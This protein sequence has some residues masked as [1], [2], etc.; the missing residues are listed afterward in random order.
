MLKAV[1]SLVPE[2]CLL[3][4]VLTSPYPKVPLSTR[5][6]SQMAGVLK[7]SFLLRKF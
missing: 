2:F 1:I 3:Y 5:F 6:T 7:R 4:R